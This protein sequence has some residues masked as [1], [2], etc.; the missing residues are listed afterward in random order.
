[1]LRRDRSILGF[2]LEQAMGRILLFYSPVAA[3][4]VT[5]G[6][7]RLSMRAA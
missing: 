3:L 1:M 2:L 7:L 4:P 5:S 6:V